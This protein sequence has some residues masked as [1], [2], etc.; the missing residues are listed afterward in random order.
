MSSIARVYTDEL[1]DHFKTLYGTWEPNIP[2]R[3]GDVGEMDGKIFVRRANVKDHRYALD[4]GEREDADHAHVDFQSTEGVEV[5]FFANGAAPNVNAR[6]EIKFSRKNAVFFNAADCASRSIEDQIT[7]GEQIL[8]LYRA[9]KWDAS[10]RVVTSIVEAKATTVLISSAN[11]GS[12]V[13]EA[14][15]DQVSNIDLT[16]A[17]IGLRLGGY[18]NVGLKVVADTGLKPLIGLSRVRP[19]RIIGKPVFGQAIVRQLE[20]ETL[21]LLELEASAS[22]SSL[23]DEL[24]FGTD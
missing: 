6:V 18:S 17:S 3:L 22:P 2:L 24:F 21:R 9:N 5:E 4:F 10:H 11:Q 14:E 15:S 19:K 20:A 16:D 8:E 7:L 12:V 1:R 23:D 13:I